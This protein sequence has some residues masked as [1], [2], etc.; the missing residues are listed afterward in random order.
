MPVSM[1]RASPTPS[2][3]AKADSLI[4]WHTIRPSTSPGAS[5][6]HATCLPSAAKKR[7]ARAAA[8]G[9]ELSPRVSSTRFASSSEEMR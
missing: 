8:T 5:P 7:S 6:T 3:S 9:E 4:T 2:P 1:S